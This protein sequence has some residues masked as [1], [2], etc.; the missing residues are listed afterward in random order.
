MQYGVSPC[1]LGYCLG[2]AAHKLEA[3]ALEGERL[4]KF[5]FQCGLRS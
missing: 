2:P 5:L 1:P 3:C 4:P